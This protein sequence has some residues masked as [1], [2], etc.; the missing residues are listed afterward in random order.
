MCNATGYSAGVIVSI[1]HTGL[2]RLF[3]QG[4]RSGIGPQMLSRVIQILT[5]LDAAELVDDLDLP[6]FR[7]HRLI[8]NYR[9]YWSVRVSGNWRII[10]QFAEGEAF[11]VDLVDY[12]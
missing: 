5:L 2:R 7:L 3:E 4:D 6:G 12:H 11:D 10:F 1:K 8:G 9:G